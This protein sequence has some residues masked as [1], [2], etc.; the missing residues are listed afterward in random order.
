MGTNCSPP[1]TQVEATSAASRG[2]GPLSHGSTPLLNLPVPQ[3]PHCKMTSY[4]E[5]CD[6]ADEGMGAGYLGQGPS[7]RRVGRT[8]A[9][10]GQ[11]HMGLTR[12]WPGQAWSSEVTKL[13]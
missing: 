9:A 12:G 5:G 8:R 3:R 6:R 1:P 2:A 7:F 11:A 4:P 10:P 13:S